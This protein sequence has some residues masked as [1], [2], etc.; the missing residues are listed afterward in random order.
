ML[1]GLMEPGAGIGLPDQVHWPVIK[2]KGNP[3][4]EMIWA[5]RDLSFD[6]QTGASATSRAI[7]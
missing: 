5:L 1:T 6:V 2:R 3:R 7:C 4:R